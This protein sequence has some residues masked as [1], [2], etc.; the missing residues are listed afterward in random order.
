V[1]MGSA[2]RRSGEGWHGRGGT[3]KGLGEGRR[4]M[5]RMAGRQ[6]GAR[7]GEGSTARR[8]VGREG[9]SEGRLQIKG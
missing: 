8:G 3:G 5:W 2:G 7:G 1:S 6:R 4:P 9:K